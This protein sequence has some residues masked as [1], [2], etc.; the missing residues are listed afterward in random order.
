M[1]QYMFRCPRCKNPDGTPLTFTLFKSNVPK[2][3]VKQSACDCG[4]MAERAF[5]LE[6]PTQAV[7]GLTPISK[8]TTTPGSF[9]NTVR[10]A[11]GDHHK[12]NPNDAPFRDSGEL[13][14]F[15]NG[16][17]DLGAPKIDQR[18]G[19]VMKRPDGSIVRG[20]AKL[21]QHDR[22]ATPSRD[23]VRKRTASRSAKW[24]GGEGKFE[25]GRGSDI[26]ITS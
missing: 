2:N 9:Y 18:T 26:K 24:R 6:I 4:E 23:D 19:Q 10:H 11:F 13:A 5:D 16:N 7:V 3:I 17:N 14:S 22:N 21:I 20:G 15:M 8:S 25:F 12:D 1:P